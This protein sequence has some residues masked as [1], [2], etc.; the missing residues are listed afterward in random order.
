MA[1]RARRI[2]IVGGGIA[3]LTLSRALLLDGHEVELVEKAPAFEALG[4]G[5]ALQGNALAVYDALDLGDAIRKIG[6]EFGNG[7]ITNAQG[8]FLASMDF[9]PDAPAVMRDSVAVH[10]AEL[11]EILVG[12]VEGAT[13]HLGQSPAEI[14]ERDE[15]P[16]WIR[17]KNGRELEGDVLVGADGIASTV[18]RHLYG[19]AAPGLRYAGYTCWRVVATDRIGLSRT[20][21]M[22]GKGARVGLVPLSKKRIYAFF[23]KNAPPGTPKE[24]HT[25]I[26]ALADA[27]AAFGGQASDFLTSMNESDVILH[28]DLFE[29]DDVVWGKGRKLLIGDA[30]HAMTPN[31][32][33]GAAQGIEDAMAFALALRQIESDDALLSQL[34]SLRHGRVVQVKARS[35]QMGAMGQWE[36]GLACALR[37]AL[38]RLS[39]KKATINSVAELL[40]PGVQLA[41]RFPGQV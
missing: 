16:V 41:S 25:A 37:N 32:G 15:G 9:G 18:R 30:A 13:L 22:W 2:L 40:R 12:A 8:S 5:I 34:R 4:A 29:L 20:I 38:V 14:G 1:K 28:H 27:F 31:L 21:E 3:G 17:L 35:R 36:N 39:P 7:G 24:G 11:Q 23:V 26:S 33:Q 19:D 6:H 10:R